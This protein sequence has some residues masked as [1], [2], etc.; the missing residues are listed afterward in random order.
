[1][2]AETVQLIPGEVEVPLAAVIARMREL[3]GEGLHELALQLQHLEELAKL[4]ATPRPTL[5]GM[6]RHHLHMLGLAAMEH[7][8]LAFTIAWR[9]Y[10]HHADEQLFRLLTS[11]LTG[12][13]YVAH[14]QTLVTRK[15]LADREG[16]QLRGEERERFM[17]GEAV[18]VSSYE[19][20]G[21]GL[22][23]VGFDDVM[24]FSARAHWVAKA[25]N[26]LLEAEESQI[27]VAHLQRMRVELER[28]VRPVHDL[29]QELIDDL[30]SRRVETPSCETDV[31]LMTATSVVALAWA[32]VA[33]YSQPQQESE[34]EAHGHLQALQ[35]MI[36]ETLSVSPRE[37]PDLLLC[38]DEMQWMALLGR[39]E[40]P[41]FILG[42][43][44]TGS[45]LISFPP[46]V[47]R[48]LLEPSLAE[49]GPPVHLHE[50]THAMAPDLD[51]RPG[52]WHLHEGLAEVLSEGFREKASTLLAERCGGP[53]TLT[54]SESYPGEKELF[55]LLIRHAGRDGA[56]D[57]VRAGLEADVLTDGLAEWMLPGLDD[58]GPLF[59]ATVMDYVR[60]HPDSLLELCRLGIRQRAAQAVETGL[61]EVFKLP[62]PL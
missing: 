50:L 15:D 42:A 58:P 52:D 23:T 16:V 22:R 14:E 36:E 20:M 45:H 8:R 37:P 62:G 40:H 53:V 19:V 35:E 49:P 31:D 34:R 47:S 24:N 4:Q 13:L 17:A 29:A 30:A 2:P 11:A 59:G 27:R 28:K 12:P 21:A 60:G 33:A 55:T 46:E 1:M 5:A 32:T 6:E 18:R 43:Y 61:A 51:T 38:S 9:Q 10:E 54:S 48:S 7:R 25:L 44:V 26:S 39:A 57:F 56:D 41:Q 3:Q